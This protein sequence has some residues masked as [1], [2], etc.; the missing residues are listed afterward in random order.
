M[1]NLPEDTWLMSFGQG[2]TVWLRG[3]CCLL[4]TTLERINFLTLVCPFCH[5][6]R[7]SR[8][9]V[10]HQK[11]IQLEVLEVEEPTAEDVEGGGFAFGVP[12]CLQGVCDGREPT[13]EHVVGKTVEV[14][15]GLLRHAAW[16]LL[17][18]TSAFPAALFPNL[19]KSISSSSIL[20]SQD[21]G[22]SLP[23]SARINWLAWK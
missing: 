1:K 2:F 8:E 23:H 4:K 16:S 19:L 12:K 6:L 14:P 9:C 15:W 3:P 22:L 5:W 13:S 21:T 7:Q 11:F 18:A 17:D 20:N 10:R